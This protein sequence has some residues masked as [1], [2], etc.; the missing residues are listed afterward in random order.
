MPG[1]LETLLAIEEIKRLKARYFRLMDTKDWAGFAEVFTQDAV[2]D[3]YGALEEKPDLSGAQAAP[4]QGRSAIVDYV[5]SGIDPLTSAHYGHM[6][7][8]E[9]LSGDSATGIWALYDILRPPAGGPFALFRGH[10]HYHERYSRAD[11]QWRIAS[12]RITR[13]MVEMS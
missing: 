4:I 6:P 7:E 11:G 10:G 8:I 1:T 9:I 13:L 3:V 12:L 2:F 5:S